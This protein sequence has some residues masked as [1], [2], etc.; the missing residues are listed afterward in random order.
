MKATADQGTAEADFDC[1]PCCQNHQQL[2]A[3]PQM[4]MSSEDQHLCEVSHLDDQPRHGDACEDTELCDSNSAMVRKP[5]G[6]KVPHPTPQQAPYGC[7]SQEQGHEHAGVKVR[8]AH[9]LHVQCQEDQ[10]IPWYG[11]HDP[12]QHQ[13]LVSWGCEF[14]C[15]PVMLL[16]QYMHSDIQ[17]CMSPCGYCRPC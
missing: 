9:Q 6:C 15:V 17:P 7:G 3:L 5:D 1:K 4:M 10:C 2:L 11:S 13:V 8:H 12:L 14:L 16:K